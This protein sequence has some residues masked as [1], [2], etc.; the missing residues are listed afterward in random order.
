MITTTCHNAAD[1]S[2]EVSVE[3]TPVVGRGQVTGSPEASSVTGLSKA[4]GEVEARGDH[5][6]DAWLASLINERRDAIELSEAIFQARIQAERDQEQQ[7]LQDLLRRMMS[8]LNDNS[9][10]E[11]PAAETTCS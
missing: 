3:S 5:R 7:A 2:L 8:G 1:L 11:S 9:P 4:I 10:T 6:E